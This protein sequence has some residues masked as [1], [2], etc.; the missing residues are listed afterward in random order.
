[1]SDFEKVCEFNKAF[2]YKVC[3]EL[4]PKDAKYRYDLI[5]EEGIVELGRAIR[6][7]DDKET[8][9]ALGDLLYVLYGAC[10]TFNFNPNLYLTSE[11]E[12]EVDI[13][14][15][16]YEDIVNSIEEVR[17]SLLYTRILNDACNNILTVIIYV[18]KF[19]YSLNIDIKDV[20]NKIHISNMSKLCVSEEEAFQ[21]VDH[22][23]KKYQIHCEKYDNYC[24][25]YGSDSPEALSVYCP[26]DSPYCYKS[27]NYWLVKNISTGKALKSINYK[28]VEL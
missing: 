3:D 16:S 9:D 24:N 17:I 28:P 6:L 11:L 7:H 14:T 2:D 15:V 19:A 25:N 23:N 8:K 5:Y 21:T 1:M 10:Y 22:Y 12:K 20:F 26:Y 18:Y 4:N 27:G 13:K